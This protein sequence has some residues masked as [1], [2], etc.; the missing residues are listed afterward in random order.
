M[1]TGSARFYNVIVRPS[2]MHLTEAGRNALGCYSSLASI[3][4]T[5]L[6][7]Y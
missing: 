3:V 5:A 7:S 2:D 6:N 1:H 4:N